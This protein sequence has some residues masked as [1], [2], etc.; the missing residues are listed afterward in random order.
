MVILASQRAYDLQSG[1]LPEIEHEEGDKSP[2]IALKELYSLEMDHG[3]L[4]RSA[5]KRVVH[6]S[7]SGYAGVSSDCSAA[8]SDPKGLIESV[9]RSLVK[10]RGL[11]STSES[12]LSFAEDEDD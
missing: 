9:D 6:F 10:E 4:F 8:R 7:G 1:S 11:E 12:E 5:I 2:V 3:R